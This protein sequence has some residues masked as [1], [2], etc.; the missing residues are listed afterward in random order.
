MGAIFGILGDSDV[1]ELERMGERLS[2]RG[3]ATLV[4]SPSARLRFGKRGVDAGSGQENCTGPISFFGVVDNRAAIARRLGRR[5]DA[6]TPAD[7]AQLVY[8]VYCKWG[9]EGFALLSGQFALAIWD[10]SRDT[11]ILARDAWASCPL[12]LTQAEGRFIFATEYKALLCIESVKAEPNLN[13]IQYIHCTKY[14]PSNAT[15]VLSID[16]VPAGGWVELSNDR[17]QRHRYM[18]LEL[19][20]AARSDREHE[21]E[22]RGSLIEAVRRQVEPYPTIGVALSGGLD[23]ALLVGTVKH[24]APERQL[25]TFTAGFGSEDGEVH[26]AAAVARHFG[27]NHHEVFLSSSELS[28]LMPETLWHMEDPIGREEKLFYYITARAA[29]EHVP[30]LLAGHSADGLFGGMPRHRVVK[31]ATMFPAFAGP[32]EEFYRYTQTGTPADSALGKLL[33]RLYFRGKH[34]APP[35]V[36]GATERPRSKGFPLSVPEPLSELLRQVMLDEPNANSAI[37]RIHSAWAVQFNSPFL[38]TDLVR[39]SFTIPDNLKIRGWRQKYILRQAGNSLLPDFML[40][41]KKGLL[42]L[43]HDDAFCEVLESMS[44]E[45][46][47]ATA[48]R[49]RGIFDVAYVDTTRRRPSSGIYPTDQLYRLWSLLMTE[50][51][52]RLFLDRRGAPP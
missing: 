18:S 14:S 51:W 8:E 1:A 35:N 13:A 45:L 33:V 31:A 48:V 7:D 38:D 27:T 28:S 24:V 50:L 36:I 20:I 49:A 5:D 4:W 42:R 23:S 37:E 34:A 30:L 43:Q 25:H 2:H 39:C 52:A 10:A 46:L 16:P 9:P 26:E 47:N 44:D 32:L 15:C 12:F 22:L 21:S 3:A 40:T 11:L 19:D 17:A 6:L 29:R 41:R